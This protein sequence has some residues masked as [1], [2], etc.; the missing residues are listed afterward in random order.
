M[1]HARVNR[2]ISTIKNQ[3]KLFATIHVY[4]ASQSPSNHA[5]DFEGEG[6][7]K[8]PILDEQHCYSK[9][10]V[11]QMIV[12]SRSYIVLEKEIQSKSHDRFRPSLR[13]IIRHVEN[14]II[15]K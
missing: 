9:I 13:D 7:Q 15:Y 3:Y 2:L 4:G 12:L 8:E 5:V 6:L 10:I 11:G 14:P 1:P